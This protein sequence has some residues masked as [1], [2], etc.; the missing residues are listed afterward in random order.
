MTQEEARG[1]IQGKLNCMKKCGVF[2]K[3]DNINYNDCDYCN[4]CYSQGNFGQQKEAFNMAI[5]AL[6][7]QIPK[8][9]MISYDE[10]VKENWCSCGVCAFGF[11]WKRT[12]H[13]KYCPNCGQKLDW[14]D[15]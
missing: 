2:N 8:K 3:E 6:E 11:G 14:S 15:E 1:F 4:Y 9:P 10:R 7:K 5:N 12:I 13:Y